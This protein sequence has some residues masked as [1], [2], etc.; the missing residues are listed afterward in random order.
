VLIQAVEDF[1]YSA[2]ATRRDQAVKRRQRGCADQF[3]GVARTFGGHKL[4]VDTM[5]L[6][7]GPDRG[8]LVSRPS[9]GGPGV[10][11]NKQLQ[12]DRFP[13]F[14]DLLW[15]AILLQLHFVWYP[16]RQLVEG[17]EDPF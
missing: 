7:P 12:M 16:R 9:V 2:I 10:E 1:E 6:E 13:V 5:A 17:T 15:Q 3:R 8:Q 4:G 11:N 14:S